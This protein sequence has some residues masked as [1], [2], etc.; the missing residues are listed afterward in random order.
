MFSLIA[1][2]SIFIP[3]RGLGTA[4]PAL[5]MPRRAQWHGRRCCNLREPSDSTD[6]NPLISIP[7]KHSPTLNSLSMPLDAPIGLIRSGA[8]HLMGGD[9]SHGAEVLMHG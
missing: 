2:L 3:H 7:Q 1:S 5:R 4:L 8:L 6:T 9:C